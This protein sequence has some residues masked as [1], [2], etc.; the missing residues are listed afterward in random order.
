MPVCIALMGS[1]RVMFSRPMRGPG[2]GPVFWGP[3]QY[4]SGAVFADGVS[5]RGLSTRLVCTDGAARTAVFFGG[6]V[7]VVWQIVFW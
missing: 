2:C 1:K 4:F 5:W 3:V 7:A 6:S